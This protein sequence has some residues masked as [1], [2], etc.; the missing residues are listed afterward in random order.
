MFVR[1]CTCLCVSACIWASYWIDNTPTETD[2]CGTSLTSI[3]GEW[4]GAVCHIMIIVGLPG[5]FG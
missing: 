5:K 3:G 2:T 1:L 4:Y